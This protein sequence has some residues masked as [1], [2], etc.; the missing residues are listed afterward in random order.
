M[1]K[2]RDLNRKRDCRSCVEDGSRREQAAEKR[3]SGK[4]RQKDFPVVNCSKE[5]CR[6]V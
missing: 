3:F 1:G 2:R 5:N 4:D 6:E